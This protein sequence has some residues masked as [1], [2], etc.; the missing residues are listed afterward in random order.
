[1]A[2]RS[3]VEAIKA[4]LNIVSVLSRYM[5]LTKSGSRYKGRCPFHK[6]DT[7]SLYVDPEKGL[8]HCFGCGAGGDMFG[9]VMKIER[10]SFPEALARLG[11]EAGVE[12]SHRGDGARE[13]LYRINTEIAQYFADNLCHPRIGK[14]ARDYLEQRGYAPPAW[15]RYGLGY[16]PNNWEGLKTRFQA[17]YGVQTLVDLGFLVKGKQGS[18]YDRFR[19]RVI[20]PIYDLTNRPIAFG[21]RAFSGEPKYLNSPKTPLFDKGRHLYGL[22]WARDKIGAKGEAILV[23]GYTDVLSLHMAGIENV[24][25]SMG[26][27]LTQGQADLLSRFTKHVVIAYDRDA[28]G[29]AASV[30]GMQ[31]LRNAGLAVRVAQFPAGE[32]PDSYVRGAGR[33]A[34]DQVI[35]A[36]IPFHVFFL[37]ALAERYD[38]TTLSGK[39]GALAE[40]RPFY[41]GL[42]SL[43]L[44]REVAQQLGELVDLPGDMVE[45][46]LKRRHA[47]REAISPAEHEGIIW[48]KEE[49]IISL[50]VRGEA[51]WEEVE[52]V[53]GPSDFS[54]RYRPVVEAIAAHG[55]PINLSELILDLDE[56][57]V[58]LVSK[59][60]IAPVIFS[61]P[62]KALDDALSRLV[63]IPHIE[64]RLARLRDEMKQAE[65]LGER[66]K[67]DELQRAYRALVVEKVTRRKYAQG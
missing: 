38:L 42:R 61:D 47:V 13:K 63:R 15:K 49:V 58:Q 60:A 33:D 23:E 28:A 34:V 57:S 45:K 12:I 9:F 5:T 19:D 8:W 67:I 35:A 32:D 31:I 14:Q 54:P 37:R 29:G 25:G 36:A 10:I 4:R 56:E 53:A 50:L 22:S 48:G 1:M 51:R 62:K 24:V 43:L 44:R 66:G 20:F 18:V 7:P 39:E 59:F 41:Q 64:E 30:R 2:D 17:R 6:D 52:R 46:E 40:A 26:T 16:A 55:D 27:S 65:K 11:A 3:D 21:G